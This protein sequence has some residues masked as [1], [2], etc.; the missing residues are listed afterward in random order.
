MLPKFPV[1]AASFPRSPPDLNSLKLS[2]MLWRLQNYATKSEKQKPAVL[3]QNGSQDLL[4]NVN[5]EINSRTPSQHYSRPWMLETQVAG[6][7]LRMS[8]QLSLQPSKG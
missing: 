1:A 8:S 5:Q 4:S 6:R 3:I 2:P 7:W